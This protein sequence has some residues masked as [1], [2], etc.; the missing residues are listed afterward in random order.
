MSKSLLRWIGLAVVVV[1]GLAVP[2]WM[3]SRDKPIVET[4]TAVVERL[5]VRV[6]TVRPA[7]LEERLVTSGTVRA[8]ERVNIV[9]EVAGKVESIEFEEGSVV[10]TGTVLVRLD[11]STLKAE[12]ERARFRAELARRQESRQRE[13]LDDG[14]ISPEE[15]DSTVGELN[16]LEAELELRQVMLEKAEIRAP[17]SGIVGLRGVS[18]GAYVT[19]QTRLTTLQDIDPIKVQFSVPEAYAR[20]LTVGDSVGFRIKGMD[21]EIQGK[22]Y[23]S[24]PAIDP[25]TRSLTLRALAP[26]PSGTLL[27][28]SFAE[29]EVAIREVADAISLP[30]VAVVPELGG[31]KVFL[32]GDGV[33]QTRIVE[34]GIRTEERVQITR[35]LEPGERVIVSNIARLRAGTEVE[36]EPATGEVP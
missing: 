5:P 24:E 25:E 11:T 10:E 30:A 9:S 7:P 3:S 26:N 2:K 33:A 35:G 17:F 31:K 6:E 16:V 29:V 28:G 34:T 14:L 18:P 4:E 15:Y 32:Y 22:I 21:E 20:E 1:V 12:R 36:I 19:S 8:N 13:L 23:A 27:P